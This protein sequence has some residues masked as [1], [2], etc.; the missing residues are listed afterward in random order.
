MQENKRLVLVA[1]PGVGLLH[2][3]LDPP[4]PALLWAK[5]A[6]THVGDRMKVTRLFTSSQLQPE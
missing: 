5:P 4:G 3:K 1:I 2:S 6:V